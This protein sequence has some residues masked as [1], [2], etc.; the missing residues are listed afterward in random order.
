MDSTNVLNALT[1]MKDQEINVYVQMD[2]KM[3]LM[4]KVVLKLSLLKKMN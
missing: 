2:M 1:Q 3:E 4:V